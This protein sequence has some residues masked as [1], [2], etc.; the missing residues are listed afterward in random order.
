M[1]ADEEVKSCQVCGASIYPEHL[2]RG[3]AGFWAGELLCAVCMEEKRNDAAKEDTAVEEPAVSDTGRDEPLTLVDEEDLAKSG[4]KMIRAFGADT[5]VGQIVHDDARFQRALNTTGRGA[6]RVRVFH[7]KL[8][9]G[10]ASYMAQS[11]NE[12]IDGNPDIEV[13]FAQTTV[14]VWE[15]K[16]PEPHLIVTVWY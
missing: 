3:Q 12:W 7:T 16:H 2:Q 1:M 10:A 5:T 15:G 13:K 9:D 6:T 14:G 8:N 4:R 11:I